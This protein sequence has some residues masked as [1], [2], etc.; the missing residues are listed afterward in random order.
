M[1]LFDKFKRDKMKPQYCVVKIFKT[2]TQTETVDVKQCFDIMLDVFTSKGY[3][4]SGVSFNYSSKTLKKLSSVYNFM[5]TK[6]VVYFDASFEPQGSDRYD[7]T[8]ITYSNH[9]LNLKDK[10]NEKDYL[11]FILAIPFDWYSL[12]LIKKVI[13]EIDMTIGLTYSYVYF[14]P[15]NYCSSSEKPLKI[16]PF[17]VSTTGTNEDEI[18]LRNNLKDIDC[19]YIPP[20]GYPVNFYNAKQLECLNG[21]IGFQEKISDNLTLV[22]YTV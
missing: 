20:K 11:D 10:T 18:T 17:S 13:K 7:P 14:M 5:E 12:E 9:L 19:G 3:S 15:K 4:L 6:D 21:D 1:G 16:T 8:G 2:H 22:T